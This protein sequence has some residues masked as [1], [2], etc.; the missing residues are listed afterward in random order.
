MLWKPA[1][2]RA[3]RSFLQGCVTAMLAFLLYLGKQSAFNWV[4][5]KIEGSKL[6]LGL[7]LALGYAVV[8]FLQNLLED[9][10]KVGRKVPKG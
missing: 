8:S 3:V 7:T 2:L 6:L 5:I 1:L 4:E 9:N 10:T